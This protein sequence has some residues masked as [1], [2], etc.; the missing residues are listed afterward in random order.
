MIRIWPTTAILIYV[1]W[2]C[3]RSQPASADAPV[4][5]ARSHPAVGQRL[6]SGKILFQK[7]F[8]SGLHRREQVGVA[9]QVGDSHIRQAG[10][11]SAEQLAGTPQFE[12]ATGDLIS[13]RETVHGP[14][15]FRDGVDICGPAIAYLTS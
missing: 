5:G 13:L 10:L 1:S 9:H 3:A 2:L 8:R 14:H 15:P 11:T 6:D 7:S 4:A 12:I